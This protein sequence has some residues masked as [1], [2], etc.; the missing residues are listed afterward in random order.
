MPDHAITAFD[1]GWDETGFRS[2]L[3][4][5]QLAVPIHV[6]GV[7]GMGKSTL[8]GRLAM[9]C[10]AAR[11]GVLVIDIKDGELAREVGRRADPDRLIA[12]TP[13]ID[14]PVWRLNLLDGPPPLVVDAVLDLFERTGRAE[15]TLMTQVRQHLT[16]ALWLALGTPGATLA[17]VGGILTDPAT[18]LRHLSSNRMSARVRQFWEDFNSRTARA[19]ADATAST[20]VRLDEFLLP[21]PLATMLRSPITS[22]RLGDWLE[23]GRLVV[24]DL[25]TGLPPRMTKLLGNLVITHLVTIAL[26]RRVEPH[27]RTFRLVADEFDQLAA[28]PFVTAIDKLRAARLMPV[29]AHQ[30]LSQLPTPLA[31]SLSGAPVH[32]FF[33]VSRHD[34]A[35]LGRALGA[36][37]ARQFTALPKHTCVLDLAEDDDGEPAWIQIE[38]DPWPDVPTDPPTQHSPPVTEEESNDERSDIAGDVRQEAPPADLSRPGVGPTLSAGTDPALAGRPDG[39]RSISVPDQRADGGT[40]VYRPFW[41]RRNTPQ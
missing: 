40:A 1:V 16:M 31:N 11:E 33:R 22:L 29:M 5:D 10:A 15:L 37:K 39:P 18:R 28:D 12:V 38:T 34:Q 9:A 41:T 32:I 24:C 14:Q 4:L 17:D 21:E 30:H 35:V 8:L 36:S 27:S 6:M 23:S 3:P 13:G 20:V 25:V 26:S 7:P 2:S 19:Q